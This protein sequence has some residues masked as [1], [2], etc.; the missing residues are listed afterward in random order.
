VR[1]ETEHFFFK[2][3]LVIYRQLIVLHYNDLQQFTLIT[4]SFAVRVLDVIRHKSEYESA[5][6]VCC[7]G[8]RRETTLAA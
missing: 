8:E 6:V 4:C 5:G 1:D 2:T 3:L 7:R